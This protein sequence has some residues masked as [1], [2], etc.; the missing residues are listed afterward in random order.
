ML[1][2]K[3]DE[4]RAALAHNRAADEL[5]KAFELMGLESIT[6]HNVALKFTNAA[7]LEVRSTMERLTVRPA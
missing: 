3:N 1:M 4:R 5:A 2:T 7:M 6:A